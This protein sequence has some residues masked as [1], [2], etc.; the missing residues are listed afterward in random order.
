MIESFIKNFEDNE[1][2]TYQLFSSLSKLGLD[3]L[4]TKLDEWYI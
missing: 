3:E 2:V 1:C 4:T